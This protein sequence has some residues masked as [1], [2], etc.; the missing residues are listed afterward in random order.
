MEHHPL[1]APTGAAKMKKALRAA[2]RAF[3][4]EIQIQRRINNLPDPLQ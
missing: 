4:R 3:W 2:W 1:D